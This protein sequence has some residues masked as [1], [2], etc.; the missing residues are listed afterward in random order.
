MDQGLLCTKIE[1]EHVY[2][3]H[4]DGHDE[5]SAGDQDSFY[6]PIVL[7]PKELLPELRCLTSFA[8]Y[9]LSPSPPY[10]S[11][12]Q[13]NQSAIATKINLAKNFCDENENNACFTYIYLCVSELVSLERSLA[14]RH[15]RELSRSHRAWE[16][17]INVAVKIRVIFD[18]F[19]SSIR[20]DN[21]CHPPNMMSVGKD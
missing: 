14:L 7:V 2:C 19:V 3:R 17:R 15:V 5:K 6:L 20:S 12:V 18:T 10:G 13:I 11:I 16:E 9:R 4:R 1:S 21:G 8:S